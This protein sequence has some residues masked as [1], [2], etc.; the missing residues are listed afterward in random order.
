MDV[1]FLTGLIGSIVLVIGAAYPI[2]KTKKPMKSVRNRLFSIWSLMM[3]IYAIIGY[4]NWWPVFFIFLEMLIILSCILMM[5]NTNDRLDT[6]IISVSGIILVIRSLFLFEWPNTLFFIIGFVV[7]WLGYAFNM[8]SIRR[9]IGLM[10][11]GALIALFSYLEAT[12]IFFW[13]NVFFAL[14]SLYYTIKLINSNKKLSKK[15]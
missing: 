5:L 10:I 14:F 15:K 4:F 8:N 11:W 9:N 3:L 1:S 13:L 12:W 6:W 7:L 2:E